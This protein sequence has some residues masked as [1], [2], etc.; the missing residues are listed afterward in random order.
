MRKE[1]TYIDDSEEG[2]GHLRNYGVDISR[3][4]NKENKD[5]DNAQSREGKDGLFLAEVSAEGQQKTEAD[6]NGRLP[7]LLLGKGEP[8]EFK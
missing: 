3:L 7:W 4:G 1:E 5:D 2:H 6:S 8:V